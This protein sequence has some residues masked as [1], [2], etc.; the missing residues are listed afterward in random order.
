M[1]IET[2]NLYK[3]FDTPKGKLHAVDNV[4]LSIKEGETL[5]VVGE[6]GCGKSTLGRVILRLHEA[7]SGNIYYNG[8]D[9]TKLNNDD[10]RKMRRFMQIIFQDPYSSLNPRYTVAEII[11]EPL[12]FFKIYDNARDRKARVEEIM[13]IVGL[14]KRSYNMY[15]HEFDGGRRQRIVIARTLSINPKFIVC[16]EPVSALD[17]SIQ[18]QIINLLM[19]LQ[20]ELKLTY[21]FI[22]HDLSVIKHISN[23]ISVMYLGEIIESCDKKTLF[24]NPKHPYTKALLSAIPTIDLNK[25]KDRILLRGEVTS[26]INPKKGCR[27]YSR[28]PYAEDGCLSDNVKLRD[29]GNNHLV[30]CIKG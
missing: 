28:C 25:K 11:S 2:K 19:D 14:S 4:N 21:M 24:E 8:M 26:P 22:S 27:F 10:M 9:I 29:I 1:F 13:D 23:N 7:D 12:S 20:K 18:A 15:P 5:G 3:Y 6:S 17:V 16:D 30:S